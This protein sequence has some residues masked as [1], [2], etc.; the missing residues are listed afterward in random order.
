MRIIDLAS[1]IH[2]EEPP[3]D[4]WPVKVGSMLFTLV[5]PHRGHE[6]AYNRWYERDHFYAGC[7]IG[8]WL[9]A[10]KRFV[11]TRALKELRFPTDSSV[12]VPLDAG[13][14]LAIYWVHE[15]HHDDHFAWANEQVL[16]L[17]RDGRGFAERTHV[18]TILANYAETIYRDDDPVPI[19]LALDHAYRGLATV[20]IDRADGV[21]HED[22]SRELRTRALPALLNDSPIACAAAW[23]PISREGGV[24]QNAP[25]DLGSDPGGSERTIQ[26]F[27]LEA[28]P[29]ELW[30]RFVDYAAT[31]ETSGLG[32]VA[33]AAPLIATQVGTDRYTDELW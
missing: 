10:G 23:L 31:I 12:A 25:M 1:R 14:Y 4:D 18:H 8:P 28:D 24:T 33:L 26:L 13:S 16:A 32:R 2:Y 17:Y 29:S 19:E 6:I 9:M 22:L 5:E 20:F 15:G 7:M 27:F 3:V 30:P 21:S 11:A